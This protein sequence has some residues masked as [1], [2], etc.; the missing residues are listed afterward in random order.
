MEKQ[1]VNGPDPARGCG[2]AELDLVTDS[3]SLCHHSGVYLPFLEVQR[4]NGDIQG[5]G[6][7]D[8]SQDR[9]RKLFPAATPSV[10]TD[11]GV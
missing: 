11:T 7:E 5:V 6:T 2:D 4:E 8:R 10:T 1:P 9:V 3:H